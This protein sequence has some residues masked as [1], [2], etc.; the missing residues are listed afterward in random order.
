MV[1]LYDE[2]WIWDKVWGSSWVRIGFVL[3]GRWGGTPVG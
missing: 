2:V 3:R 1:W